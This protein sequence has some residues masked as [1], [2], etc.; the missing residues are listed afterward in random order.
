MIKLQ[1]CKSLLAFE[2]VKL[3]KKCFAKINLRLSFDFVA[4]ENTQKLG[5]NTISHDKLV[6]YT[7]K[8]HNLSKKSFAQKL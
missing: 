7:N 5:H 6:Q 1:F 8:I 4:Y 2:S 3:K